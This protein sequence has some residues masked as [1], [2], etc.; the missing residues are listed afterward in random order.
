MIEKSFSTP[1][2]RGVTSAVPE[3]E[4]EPEVAER[5]IA[6]LAISR[7]RCAGLHTEY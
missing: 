1:Q 3:V 7:M 5:A 4:A 2:M 6:R